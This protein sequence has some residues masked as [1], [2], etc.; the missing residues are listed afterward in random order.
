M[1]AT[2]RRRPTDLLRQPLKTLS[3]IV[4][5]VALAASAPASAVDESAPVFLERIDVRAVDVEVV[6]RRGGQVVTGLR[7]EDF[8]ISLDGDD[9][10]IDDFAE[11][12]AGVTDAGPVV[13]RYLVFVDDD[14][15]IP[16]RRN[17]ALGRLRDQ[18]D[19]LAD[20][21]R[22]AVVAWNGQQVELL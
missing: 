14:F 7:A 4:A 15:S 18:V 13:T 10:A 6:V 22:M 1:I 16:S 5:L 19:L 11:I 8:R 21:D 9:V 12:Q 20:Q 2:D 17:A 3:G